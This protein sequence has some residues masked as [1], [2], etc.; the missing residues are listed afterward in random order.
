MT[1]S[2]T[3]KLQGVV[4]ITRADKPIGTYLLLWPTY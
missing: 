2:V 4:K 3:A 1:S